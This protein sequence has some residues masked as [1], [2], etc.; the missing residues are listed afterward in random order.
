MTVAFSHFDRQVY[1]IIM[2]SITLYATIWPVKESCY[3]FGQHTHE[4]FKPAGMRERDFQ[5][6]PLIVN[7]SPT[8]GMQTQHPDMTH[9]KWYNTKW[10]KHDIIIASI[11]ASTELC[12][13]IIYLLRP[14]EMSEQRESSVCVCVRLC[15]CT[16]CWIFFFYE[17]LGKLFQ[18]SSLCVYFSLRQGHKRC[19]QEQASEK[20]EGTEGET[21]CGGEESGGAGEDERAALW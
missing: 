2:H 3:R 6:L 16:F 7:S 15:V 1:H 4:Q 10:N 20:S 21:T 12:C 9:N 13:F 17:L 18:P 14:S 11:N 5:S 19:G 8:M